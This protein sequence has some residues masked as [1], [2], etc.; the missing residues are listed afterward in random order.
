MSKHNLK[1]HRFVVCQTFFFRA[2]LKRLQGLVYKQ[3]LD[4]SNRNLPPPL[5]DRSLDRRLLY[6]ASFPI[7]ACQPSRPE[8]SPKVRAVEKQFLT[9]WATFSKLTQGTWVLRAYR[10][11]DVAAKFCNQRFKSG[12]AWQCIKNISLK[13]C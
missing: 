6:Q 7:L 12:R 13:I 10:Q 9:P 3:L 4:T 11:C 1:V 5:F 2:A 8:N